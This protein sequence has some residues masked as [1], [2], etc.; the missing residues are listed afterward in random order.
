M[1]L[2]LVYLG[3]ALVF[4]FL[5]SIAEAVLLR[6]NRGYIEALQENNATAAQRLRRFRDSPEE[7]LSA[8]LTL[9]TVAHTVGAAGVGHQAAVIFG[10]Q[11]LG[12]YSAILTFLILVGSEIIPKTLGATHWRKLAP[13]MALTVHALTIVLHPVIVFLRGITNRLSHSPA[14]ER[15]RNEIEST[16]LLASESEHLSEAESTMLRNVLTMRQIPVRRIMT[17]RVIVF[18]VA[19]EMTVGEYLMQHAESPFSRIPLFRDN[20]DDITGYVLRSAILESQDSQR[21]LAAIRRD[22][23]V[24]F[25]TNSAGDSFARLTSEQQHIAVVANEFGGTAGIVTLEDIIET[26]VGHEIIDELDPAVDLRQEAREKYRKRVR[27]G[28]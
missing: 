10:E 17:P 11:W 20:I 15:S 1:L 18:A 27:D 19:E 28:N 16:V 26:L 8:I 12:L 9:N 22:L 7:P 21:P 3:I 25:E 2:L 5:C 13:S 23:P 6:V 24:I 14:A 4:S